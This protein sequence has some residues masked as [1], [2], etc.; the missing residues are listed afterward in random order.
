MPQVREACDYIE[1]S[2]YNIVFFLVKHGCLCSDALD[3]CSAFN[4]DYEAIIKYVP[5]LLEVDFSDLLLPRY[6]YSDQLEII[7]QST[8]KINAMSVHCNLNFG[9]CMRLISGEVTAEWVKKS[10]V[11]CACE[12]TSSPEDQ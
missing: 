9:L 8:G 7:K 3:I 5:L 10:E 6:D 11:L 4:P 12:P 1:P 2:F